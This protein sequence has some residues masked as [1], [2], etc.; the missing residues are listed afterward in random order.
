MV[1]LVATIALLTSFIACGAVTSTAHRAFTPRL[2]DSP[3][4]S[5]AIARAQVWTRTNVRA[6]NIRTGPTGPGA[7][8]FN[9]TVTCKYSPKE[10]SGGSPKFA[11]LDGQDEAEGEVRRDQRAKC[12]AEVAATR[13]MWALGFGADRMYPVRVICRG[14]PHRWAALR[15]RTSECLFDPATIERKMP[16][17]SSSEAWSWTE[18]DH[19]DEK[20]GRRAARAS[21]RA[22][23]ARGVPAAHRHQAAAAAGHLHGRSRRGR[24]RSVRASVHDDQRPGPD[25]R[26]R[27]PVQRQRQAHAPGRVGRDAGLEASTRARCVGNLPK[28]F[29]GTLRIR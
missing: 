14:C 18:L 11:C 16:A 5:N 1:R 25:V 20:T 6:M 12:Y 23:A 2:D 13:L 19:I 21:R 22:E 17:A 28:S 26:P 10:L 4:R 3:E 9:A 8:P 7:F 29:T 27:Q 15:A 24:A